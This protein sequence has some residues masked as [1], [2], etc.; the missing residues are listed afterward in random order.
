MNHG[1][2]DMRQTR[3][4]KANDPRSSGKVTQEFETGGVKEDRTIFMSE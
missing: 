2:L 1:S 3:G 4:R